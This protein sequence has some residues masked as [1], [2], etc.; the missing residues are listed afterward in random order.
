MKESRKALVAEQKKCF[1]QVFK[2]EAGMMCAACNGNYAKFITKNADGSFTM[3]VKKDT[4]ARLQKA[5]YKYL[6]ERNTATKY[7]QNQAKVKKMRGSKNK[8]QA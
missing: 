8:I 1:K 4:C 6:V 5:C 2:Y 7:V 3:K